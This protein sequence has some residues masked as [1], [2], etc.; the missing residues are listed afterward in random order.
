MLKKTFEKLRDKSK[1]NNEMFNFFGTNFVLTSNM[2]FGT[3]GIITL[4]SR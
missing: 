4:T 1:S 3:E 2:P